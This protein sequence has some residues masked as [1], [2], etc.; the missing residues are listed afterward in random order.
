VQSSGLLVELLCKVG[1]LEKVVV[2]QREEIARRKVMKGRPVIQPSGMY[3]GTEPAKP[4]KQEKPRRR[5][6]V[7]PQVVQGNRVN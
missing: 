2:E 6:K 1:T 3:K 5:V 7:T 4:A